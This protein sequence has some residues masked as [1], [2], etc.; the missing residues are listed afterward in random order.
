MARPRWTPV[1]TVE[2]KRAKRTT[3]PSDQGDASSSNLW[4]REA[5][6]RVAVT[7]A[8]NLGEASQLVRPSQP[9]SDSSARRILPSLVAA[10]K[11]IHEAQAEVES[12]TPRLRGRPRGSKSPVKPQPR[13]EPGFHSPAPPEVVVRPTPRV[14]TAPTS[15]NGEGEGRQ[16]RGRLARLS[17]LRRRRRG[18]PVTLARGERWKRRLPLMCR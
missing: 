13:S 6:A 14:V 5:D 15:P 12:V 3:A 17:A 10:E 2:V 11:E 7:A 16:Q 4:A 18:A 9:V 8:P 1:F